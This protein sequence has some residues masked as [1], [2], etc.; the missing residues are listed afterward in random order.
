[1]ASLREK[2]KGAI[3]AML[4]L[5]T[6]VKKGNNEPVWK[7]LVYD[8]AGQDIIS[9][10]LTVNELRELG[11][12]LHLQLHSDR[13]AIPDTP[14][15]YFCMP[16]KE[17]VERICRDCKND[18]YETYYINFIT[19]VPRSLLEDLANAA[20]EADVVAQISKVYDQHINFIS[21]EEDLFC[22]RPLNKESIS[23][24]AL[25]NPRAKD[26]EVENSI[27]EIV[28]SLFSV[29]V[30]S[31]TI[32]IIRCPRNNAAD[33][34]AKRLDQK[35]R[36]HLKNTRTN[37]FT[38]VTSSR[39]SFQRPVLILL[40]RTIDLPT[41]L[42]H[43]W[44]YQALVHDVLGMKSNRISIQSRTED[45]RPGKVKSY[46][47]DT[48]RDFFWQKHRGSPFPILPSEV[49]AELNKYKEEAAQMSALS[50]AIGS[51]PNA[52]PDNVDLSAN[53]KLLTSAVSNLPALTEKKRLIDM[54]TSIAWALL[55][56]IKTRGLD[57]FFEV[58][59]R[60]M[61]RSYMEIPI[62]TVLKD[63]KGTPMDKLRLYIIYYLTTESIPENTQQECEAI[64][65]GLMMDLSC[66]N[67]VKRIKQ[68]SKMTEFSDDKASGGRGGTSVL[69]RMTN[70][71]FVHG[72]DLIKQGVKNFLP[73]SIKLPATRIVESLMDQ[74][75][76]AETEE[77][78]YY[79]PKWLR[80]AENM[81][82]L[83]TPFT[84]AIVFVVG[85]GNY[86]EYTNL[87][88][89]VQ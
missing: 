34:V 16:T 64:L 60:C 89:F 87:R 37:L 9:P 67:Y 47:I 63:E 77:Y 1:M 83:K 14:V 54:H 18:L 40:D 23:Y 75:H 69:S 15:V 55:D 8:R 48:A 2:Q 41:L 85:G 78:S 30:T 10:I 58:E 43:T 71:M 59:E 29:L 44:T 17:N 3:R 4:N 21:L 73:P 36:D 6:P 27:D 65:Q 20:L 35:L 52:V 5:N 19:A 22:V 11:V 39:P 61:N 51:D 24:Y 46:D 33:M 88:E 12:T 72:T 31:G 82:R 38:E 81:T 49:E 25:N 84:E 7:V 56:H 13:D 68:I 76:S 62:Q 53:A 74:K 80:A 28:E 42:H 57:M 26:I 86:V 45:N 79:D 32:P 70:Q 50:Y 66:M